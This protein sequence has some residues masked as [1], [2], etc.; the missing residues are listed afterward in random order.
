M[1][2][3]Q[4]PRNTR[5]LKLAL[6]RYPV[7]EVSKRPVGYDVRVKFHEVSF[8]MS[9]PFDH[10]DVRPNDFVTLY[11]EIPFKEPVDANALPTPKQ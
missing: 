4:L 3:E 2:L 10:I 1:P 7:M 6:G 8:T 9:I 5:R 11:T